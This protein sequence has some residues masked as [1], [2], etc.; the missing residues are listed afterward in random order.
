MPFLDNLRLWPLILLTQTGST[1]IFINIKFAMLHM[2]WPKAVNWSA[3]AASVNIW[4]TDAYI[5]STCAGKNFLG[6]F[7]VSICMT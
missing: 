3:N 7:A 5:M 6:V 4:Y 1:G 2:L